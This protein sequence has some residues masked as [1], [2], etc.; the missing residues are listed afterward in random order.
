MQSNSCIFVGLDVH[1]KTVAFCAKNADGT[2]V[3]QGDVA[4]NRKSLG[5]W[6]ELLPRPWHG[7]ME[8]TLFTGWIYDFLKPRCDR[9]VVAQ[10]LMMRAIC[11]SKKKNDRVDAQKLADALRADLVPE[12]YMAPSNI[13][14]LRRVLRFRNLMVRMAVRMKNKCSGLLMEVGAQYDKKKLR[15][16][17]YFEQLM[18]DLAPEEMPESVRKLLGLSRAQVELFSRMEKQLVKALRTNVLIKERVERLKT[19]D[20]VGDILALTWVLEV[21]ES[22]RFSSVGKAHSYCGLTSAQSSSG[23]T[24]K[25]MPISKLRN[26]HLQTMLIEAAKLAPH[27][28]EELAALAERER[29]R[30]HR[31]RAT[32]VVAR[33][34]VSYMLAVD[35]SGKPFEK[36]T[37]TAQ[38]TEQTG[39]NKKA[40]AG[41]KMKSKTRTK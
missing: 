11:A 33:K 6:A 21:G 37:A 28:N 3:C 25:R 7:V 20:G 16:K 40:K 22:E 23:E 36:R 8:A 39:K 34:L 41:V 1:K 15:G 19:I 4:A 30:G 17:G 18:K 12:C 38:A 13:R 27:H 14:E 35:R 32:L 5:Q 29:E 10:P 9:L 24:S 26:K 2:I 31:N